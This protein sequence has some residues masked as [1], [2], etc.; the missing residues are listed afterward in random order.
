VTIIVV[1]GALANKP[2][3]GGAAWTRMSWVWGLK[4]LG[5]E[6]YFLEQIGRDHCRDASGGPAEF[7][8]CAGRLYFD[9][10]M[11]EF[12]L[13]HAA[14]LI[15]ENGEQIHGMRLTE[16]E[17]LAGAAALLVNIS[18]HLAWP[19]VT[20]HFRWRAYI[21]LDPGYTQL[22]HISG[23]HGSRLAG[24][25][26]YFT[27]GENI[28][29]AACGL[30]TCDLYWRSIRQPVVLDHW[31]VAAA[32]D[33]VPDRFTT[34]ASWRGF[35]GPI[36]HKGV[37]YGPKAHEF[38]KFLQLPRLARQTFEIALDVD[39][40]DQRDLDR[41]RGNG[42]RI[43]DPRAAA[44][45]PH[46][47]RRYVQAS[48]AEFSAAQGMYVQTGCGWL[49]DR[50]VR[51]LASGKPA[52]VQDTGFSRNYP[53]GV[54]LIPFRTLEQ[55][56]ASAQQIGRYYDQHSRAARELAEVFFDS[57]KVLAGFVEECGL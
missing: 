7:E 17:D 12:G 3:Y 49:A 16:L 52:L 38:R 9:Q 34:V 44:G 21:D 32:D 53:T 36:S 11:A 30:P 50:T 39:P 14:T 48:A 29:T 26:L 51:Y 22:W 42:W 37:T 47:F 15:Y 41:L 35:Y 56:V 2:F 55:A 46:E 10:V 19:A 8:M 27:V 6:V 45:D 1:A 18:G 33:E 4:R 23:N 13:S 54:G 28:G 24:H 5:F 40:A 20:K 57:D 43:V 25:D 31:P